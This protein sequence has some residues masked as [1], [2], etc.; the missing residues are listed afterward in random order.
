MVLN[1]LAINMPSD[2]V[3]NLVHNGGNITTAPAHVFPTL[4]ADPIE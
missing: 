4:H 2:M 3:G 1:A